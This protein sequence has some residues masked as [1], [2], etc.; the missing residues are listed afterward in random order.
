MNVEMLDFH[1][2]KDVV[3][4]SG[5]VAL[6]YLEVSDETLRPF[7]EFGISLQRI[8]CHDTNLIV[9]KTNS[10]LIGRHSRLRK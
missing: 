4:Q 3:F 9:E 1:A 6:A 8:L 2:H 10:L 7:Q 5:N